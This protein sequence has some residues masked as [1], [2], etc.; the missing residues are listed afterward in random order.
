MYNPPQ[1][2]FFPFY[3]GENPLTI[4]RD[5]SSGDG[6]SQEDTD[7]L[8]KKTK[9]SLE[10]LLS[11]DEPNCTISVENLEKWDKIRYL[12]YDTS[13]YR[14]SQM[15]DFLNPQTIA[16]IVSHLKPNMGAE[17]IS[18]LPPE[19]QF[20]V[21]QFLVTMQPTSPE[22]IEE[23]KKDFDN[24]LSS[25]VN[26]KFEGA[27]GVGFI[28]EIMLDFTTGRGIMK[29][30]K[31]KSPELVD[32]ICRLIPVWFAD[33]LLFD[34]EGISRLHDFDVVCILRNI[35]TQQWALALKGASEE[36]KSKIF[37]NISKRAGKMLQEEIEYLGPQPSSEVERAQ[38][39]IVDVIWKLENA[40]EVT[41]QRR[42]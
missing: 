26:Q 8:E 42:Y 1:T 30:L 33:R 20:A 34:F 36:L 31:Q 32:K 41:I 10:E 11:P 25:I 14:Q 17:I 40:G 6:L 3:E 28:A 12:W 19:K 7:W 18:E 24:W 16:M 23:I 2:S 37:K 13:E 15:F 21:I 38:Q 27:H 29:N 35:E 22:V 5:E 9:A 4:Q 39:E